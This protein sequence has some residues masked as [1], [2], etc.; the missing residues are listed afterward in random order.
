M[1]EEESDRE[2]ETSLQQLNEPL[3]NAVMAIK[4]SQQQKGIS[5]RRQIAFVEG[6]S[7]I[8]RIFTSAGIPF[9]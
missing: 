6:V 5:L 2:A 3:R 1:S 4:Q 7:Q 8:D 9:T